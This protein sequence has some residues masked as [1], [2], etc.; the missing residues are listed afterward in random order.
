MF[1]REKD[2]MIAVYRNLELMME[3]QGR[4]TEFMRCADYVLKVDRDE[5]QSCKFIKDR[6]GMFS[7]NTVFLKKVL[8]IINFLYGYE[9]NSKKE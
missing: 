7:E 4:T 3:S 2:G 8:E 5:P 9:K 1:I 6:S